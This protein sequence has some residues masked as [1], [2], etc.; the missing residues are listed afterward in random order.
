MTTQ[1][2]DAAG[3][4]MQIRRG[5][6]PRLIFSVVDQET[7]QPRN[8]TR[9]TI[10]FGIAS[11]R[12]AT[13]YN[14]GLTSADISLRDAINVDPVAWIITVSLT[15]DMTERLPIGNRYVE[16]T[17]E[18]KDGNVDIVAAGPALILDTTVPPA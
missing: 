12:E 16:L 2:L 10:T 14:L 7:G 6:T 4:P 9:T 5:T 18:D 3:Q 17:V 1:L 8:L 13:R 15:S 11:R